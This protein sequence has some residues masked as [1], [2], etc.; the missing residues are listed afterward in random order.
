MPL[1]DIGRRAARAIMRNNTLRPSGDPACDTED[2]SIDGPGGAIAIRLYTPRPAAPGLLPGLVFFHGGGFIIGDIES[3]DGLCRA[4]CDGSSCKLVSV[5]YRLAPEHPFP[6][7]VEDAFAATVFVA[8]QAEEL[9]IDPD[10]LAVGGDSAGGNL[11]A[12]AA[13]L[14]KQAGAPKL[15]FQL[16]IYPVAQMASA[17]EIAAARA[18]GKSYFL[19]HQALDWFTRWY[20]PDAR[21][22]GDPRL[23]PLLSPDLRG[24]PPAYVVTAGLDPLC[25]EGRDYADALGR[26]GVPVTHV[27]YPGMIHGFFSFRGRLPKAREAATAAAGALRAALNSPGTD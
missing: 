10:R 18:G 5:D 14:A 2:H 8:A 7:A 26:A 19:E 13:Q 15:C 12:V 20:A 16:L 21:H 4:L 11:A 17:P 3:H 22:R 23:S 1:W 9:G 25:E 24:L 6:A 27:N